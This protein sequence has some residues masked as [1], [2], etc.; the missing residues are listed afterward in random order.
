MT[1]F[2]AN[3]DTEAI[4]VMIHEDRDGFATLCYTCNN[5]Y[6]WGQASPKGVSVDINSVVVLLQDDID[7]DTDRAGLHP[8]NSN[9]KAY[10]VGAYPFDNDDRDEV[11]DTDVLFRVYAPSEQSAYINARLVAIEKGYVPI[12][13]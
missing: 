2:C 5:A 12:K 10:G 1:K 3:C 6:R 9:G 4:R 8:F 11:L 7:R 13:G